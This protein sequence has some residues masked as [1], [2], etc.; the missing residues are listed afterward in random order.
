MVPAS[1]EQLT[2]RLRSGALALETYLEELERRID[3]RESEVLAL[4][5]EPGRFERLRRQARELTARFPEPQGRPPLFAVPVGIKDIFRVDGF[6]TGAGSRLPSEEFSGGESQA[7]GRLKEAGALILGK[8][9]STEFAYFA[10]GPTRNPHDPGRTPGGSSSGSAAAVGAGECPLALGT[11]TIG[12]IS[13]PASYCGVV[14]Y[15]PS[16]D[17]VS[18]RGVIP[19]SPS[20]DHI[21]PFAEDVG[22]VRLAASLLCSEWQE[23]AS[24]DRPTLGVP[25]GTYLEQA[26]GEGLALFA[27]VCERLTEAGYTLIRTEAMPEFSAIVARH[28]TLVAAEAALVHERWFAQYGTLYHT[29][30]AELLERGRGVSQSDLD[31][32]RAGRQE[33]R[34]E[35]M[36]Q[37]A[38]GGIDLWIS[39]ASCGVAPFGLE[40]TGSPVMNLPWTHAGLPSV[41][42]PAATSSEGLPFGLQIA[43]GFWRD[44][45]LLGWAQQIERALGRADG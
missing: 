1:L 5:P 28:E 42:I 44:E 33:L 36:V 12:S 24:A 13:R 20:L 41:A 29:K 16:Y 17:R 45:E 25:V 18:R 27:G 38:E 22:G 14:G 15:K 6:A 7:V 34:R 9:V 2:A 40:S 8:T 3:E 26:D 43:A 10:P 32:A 23:D 19:L 21:G 4:V 35:L 11:Q 39:P 37:M 31:S 30:T